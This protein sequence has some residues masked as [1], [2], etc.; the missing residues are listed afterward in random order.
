MAAEFVEILHIADREHARVLEWCE[1]FLQPRTF[2]FA[3]EDE[4]ALRSSICARN[5]ANCHRMVAYS[6]SQF[7]FQPW[8]EWVLADNASDKRA[9]SSRKRRRRPFDEQRK[10]SHHRG[11]EVVLGILG[12]CRRGRQQDHENLYDEQPHP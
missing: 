1:R 9:L 3:D 2:R 8:A 12:M 4:I 5:S 11:L 7:M 6:I 10:V